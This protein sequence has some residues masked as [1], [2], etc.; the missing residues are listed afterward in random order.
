MLKVV[1]NHTLGVGNRDTQVIAL[2]T[3]ALALTIRD[4]QVIVI[5]KGVS[6]ALALTIRL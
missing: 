2:R 6:S 3:F 1:L 4:T 5:R